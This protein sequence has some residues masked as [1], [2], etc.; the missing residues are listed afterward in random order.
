MSAV[1]VKETHTKFLSTQPDMQTGQNL[2][3][4]TVPKLHQIQTKSKA[5]NPK[6]SEDKTPLDPQSRNKLNYFKKMIAVKYE[7]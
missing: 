3:F 4:A 6:P 2:D 5:A 1:M 7:S